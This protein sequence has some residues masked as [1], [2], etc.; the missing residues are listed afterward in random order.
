MPMDAAEANCRRGRGGARVRPAGY[1]VCRCR[2]E[3]GCLSEEEGR[4]SP[5]ARRARARPRFIR[6]LSIQPKQSSSW[7]KM[8]LVYCF[9]SLSSLFLHS[10]CAS[11]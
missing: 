3:H 4:E 9:Y 1:F 6:K 5:L 10:Q 7:G 8:Y 11:V 2:W